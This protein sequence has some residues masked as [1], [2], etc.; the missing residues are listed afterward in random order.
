MLHAIDI[1]HGATL[2]I[3]I[4]IHSTCYINWLGTIEGEIWEAYSTK[5]QQTNKKWFFDYWFFHL[6]DMNGNYIDYNAYIVD[7][8]CFWKVTTLLKNIKKRSTGTINH[9]MNVLNQ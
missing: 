3:N 2:H 5:H 4:V 6:T 1:T 9:K 8:I 7:G